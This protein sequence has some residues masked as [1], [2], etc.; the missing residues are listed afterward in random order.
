MKEKVVGDDVNVED[1]DEMNK[2]RQIIWR[3]S[4]C[5]YI[6][7]KDHLNMRMNKEGTNM[8]QLVCV[9]NRQC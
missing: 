6:L 2:Q 1:V 4:I 3:P 7:E 5:L 8:V 9:Q